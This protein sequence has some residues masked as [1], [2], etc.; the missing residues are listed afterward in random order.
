[1][2]QQVI[3]KQPALM[4]HFVLILVSQDWLVSWSKRTYIAYVFILSCAAL[5]VLFNPLKYLILS[6]FLQSSWPR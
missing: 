5:D 1:M 3:M 6:C 4:C 2:Q